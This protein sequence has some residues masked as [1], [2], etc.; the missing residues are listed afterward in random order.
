[1]KSVKNHLALGDNGDAASSQNDVP[2]SFWNAQFMSQYRTASWIHKFNREISSQAPTS[3][4][5]FFTLAA[6]LW[7]WVREYPW[8]SSPF[9]DARVFTAE[10]AIK[11]LRARRETAF[12]IKSIT[13]PQCG[14][15]RAID[16]FISLA[17]L[18]KPPLQEPLV[19]SARRKKHK[20]GMLTDYLF[21]LGNKNFRLS[22]QDL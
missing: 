4:I 19:S 21:C 13:K 22:D 16:R 10:A 12:G 17:Q 7:F 20:C 6:G 8:G 9:S 3:S 2:N 15:V 18:H 14:T 5:I 1:M 11:R